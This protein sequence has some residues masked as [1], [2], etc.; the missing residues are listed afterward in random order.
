MVLIAVVNECQDT[1]HPWP[2][3]HFQCFCSCRDQRTKDRRNHLQK[4]RR[5]H[6]HT[7]FG[8]FVCLKT[9]IEGINKSAKIA[10]L[11][12]PWLILSC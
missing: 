7:F 3:C 6:I 2:H 8:L 5:C 9:L 11:Y 4:I 12:S 1:E 10:F